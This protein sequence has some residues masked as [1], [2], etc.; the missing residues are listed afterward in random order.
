MHSVPRVH[1]LL[2]HRLLHKAWIGC[3]FRSG[4][5]NVAQF[6]VLLEAADFADL[7]CQ[8]APIFAVYGR[9]QCSNHCHWFIRRRTIT[10]YL[11]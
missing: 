5:K 2:L 3:C 1:F 9:S 6:I 7:K 10:V 4:L 11:N 8:T